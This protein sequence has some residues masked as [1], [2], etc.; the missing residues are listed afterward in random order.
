MN[1]SRPTPFAHTLSPGQLASLSTARHRSWQPGQTLRGT[2]HSEIFASGA[3]ASGAGF[4]LA[5]ALDDLATRAEEAGAET[6]DRRGVLWVQDR[7]ALKL[8]GRPY[9][10]GLP[11]SLRHRLIHVRTENAQDALFALEEGVRCRELACVIGEVAGNPRAL[12]FTASRRLTLAAERHGVALW[13][14]R[15]DAAHDLSSARM[16][17]E[18]GSAP[19]DAPPWNAAAPGLP[20]WR[21]VLFRSRSHAPGQWIMY[22]DGTGRIAPAAQPSGAA[23]AANPVAVAGAAGD[24]SLAAR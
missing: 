23:A 19:S 18:V 4:A 14:V 1:P 7:T 9:R 21:A 22:D 11:E 17:W 16:R 20:T 12:D 13:L 2:R 8:T 5:L 6:D 24:R 3:E 15:L 10:P